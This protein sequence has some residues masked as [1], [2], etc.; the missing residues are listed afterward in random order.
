MLAPSFEIRTYPASL[1]VSDAFTECPPRCGSCYRDGIRPTCFMNVA[2]I[3]NSSL[4]VSFNRFVW[5]VAR[6]ELFLFAVMFILTFNVS[7]TIRLRPPRVR[8]IFQYPRVRESVLV[9]SREVSR[10]ILNYEIHRSPR[11]RRED[12]YENYVYGAS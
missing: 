11:L 7:A 6:R 3:N 4:P 10:G 5:Q 2:V 1:F 8:G 12:Y 9:R